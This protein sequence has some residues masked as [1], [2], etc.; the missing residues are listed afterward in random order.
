MRTLKTAG[1]TTAPALIKLQEPGHRPPALYSRKGPI[2][3]QLSLEMSLGPSQIGRLYSQ[4]M[5]K[6][7]NPA[8]MNV[9]LP[10]NEVLA[11][12]DPLEMIRVYPNQI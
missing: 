3:G 9:P 1:R 12:D 10:G 4:K 2:Q 11:D 6:S 5:M 8:P 7:L